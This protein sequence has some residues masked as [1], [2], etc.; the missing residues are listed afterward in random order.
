MDS[1]KIDQVVI[2]LLRLS[3]E[4]K[5]MHN[6]RL[7]QSTTLN[8]SLQ[9]LQSEISYI[10]HKVITSGE[11]GVLRDLERGEIEAMTTKV[12]NL[13]LAK[14]RF[15]EEDVLLTSLDYDQRLRRHEAIPGAHQETFQWIFERRKTLVNAPGIRFVDWLEAGNDLF[16]ISGK[17]GSGKSTLMKL[18]ANAPS[19]V[20]YLSKWAVG[21]K[22]LVI[23]S[24]Y[25]WSAGSPIQKSQE[26]L[27]RS[28]LYEILAQVP[29]LIESI[30]EER[31]EK[32]KAGL[33]F[34]NTWQ[35]T[36]LETSLSKLASSGRLPVQFCFFID[37]LDEYEGD[38]S[39]I[40]RSLLT[41]CTCSDIKVCVASRPWN[42]FE[43]NFSADPLRK[44]YVHELTRDDIQRFTE[45][46]LYEH[47]SWS[48]IS[49]DVGPEFGSTL[50]TEIV[51]RAQGVFLW[52]FLVTDMLRKGLT[53]Y[54]SIADLWKR[55][56]SLPTD[57]EPFFKHILSAVEPFYH[58]KMAGALLIT[59][60][61][62]TPFSIVVYHFHDF[63]Y[64]DRDFALKNSF[65]VVDGRA[66]KAI[67]GRL[68]GWC[69]GLLEARG[70]QV[71]FLHRT[72]KDFLQ[73]GEIISFLTEKS[74]DGFNAALSVVKAYLAWIKSTKFTYTQWE[75][76]YCSIQGT[77]TVQVLETVRYAGVGQDGDSAYNDTCEI[78]LDNLEDSILDMLQSDQLKATV[79]FS[80]SGI[81]SDQVLAETIR[82]LFREL[83]LDNNLGQYISRKMQRDPSYFADFDIPPLS[84][85][86][87]NYVKNTQDSVRDTGKHSA[88]CDE[89]DFS[90]CYDVIQCLLK[91]GEN[92]NEPMIYDSTDLQ[93][94]AWADFVTEALP[95]GV[96][97]AD[98]EADGFKGLLSAKTFFRILKADVFMLLIHHGAN[99]NAL[100][101]F[102][103]SDY[104]TLSP[105]WIAWV[106]LSF[107]LKDLWY[108]SESYLR[109]LKAAFECHA[110]CTLLNSMRTVTRARQTGLSL[111]KLFGILVNLSIKPE[112]LGTI[113]PFS[114]PRA[115]T[116]L[117]KVMV[118]LAR[119][120]GN[121]L[122]WDE[123]LPSLR[124]VCPQTQ[125]RQLLRSI[126]KEEDEHQVK[127]RRGY[128]R[129]L[130][131][132]DSLD[133]A[134]RRR[135]NNPG[136]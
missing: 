123:I 117:A 3:I 12:A 133:I 57:L 87:Q 11:H 89:V 40:S 56:E 47:R 37:G 118:E 50:V 91:H 95:C 25:F 42:V 129:V 105:F 100:V 44:L 112:G 28:L 65:T 31:W 67:R 49:T 134:K 125:F 114:D 29:E 27:L 17:P 36:E 130:T 5:A 135:L 33:P 106:L 103:V 109:V 32:M 85:T 51:D 39:N 80:E 122:D 10:K 38:H 81:S 83:L 115:K 113:N 19:T 98:E 54:D 84:I 43:E 23:A 26:G 61:A 124:Q 82:R 71:E 126:G 79:L 74:F 92:P 72:V 58:Q 18:I 70:D 76:D 78:L 99:P 41:L 52:V 1:N 108:Y 69:K 35:L 120:A 68:N 48:R 94:T 75:P 97:E 64:A 2:E 136:V 73:T 20:Q 66:L 96:G 4:S 59:L 86:L 93:I 111:W 107:K 121:T 131:G 77:F 128:K 21:S 63:E 46:R 8:N 88:S 22:K 104:H 60:E 6:E 53:N 55:L 110:D 101:G 15:A 9:E 132:A 30:C 34:H 90:A 116:F 102:N 7:Q 45:S 62:R 14:T 119:F 24:H 16:W 127:L 13:S